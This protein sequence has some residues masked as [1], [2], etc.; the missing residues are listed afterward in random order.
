MK[1]LEEKCNN[2]FESKTGRRRFCSDKCKMKHF[3]KYGKKD[4]A[5]K[6]DIQILINEFKSMV[7][8]FLGRP[9]FR[10]ESSV[11]DASKNYKPVND[12][13][14]SFDKMNQQAGLPSFQ[15]LLNGMAD[16]HFADEK[17]DY[18]EKIRS[19]T[20][21]SEKQQNLLLSNLWTKN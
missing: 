20:Y 5:T 17:E 21:L 13:P 8:E 14:L 10:Q 18:A 6:F 19:A 11:L 9:D 2:D 12:E 3:R 16:V 4:V 15:D 7:Q 1:C